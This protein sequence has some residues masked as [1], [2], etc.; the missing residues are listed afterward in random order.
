MNGLNVV[1][2]CAP[3]GLPPLRPQIQTEIVPTRP[4]QLNRHI[5][6]VVVTVYD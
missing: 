6:Y 5:F 3:R 4:I 1:S 2:E